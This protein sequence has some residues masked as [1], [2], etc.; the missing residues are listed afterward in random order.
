MI[1]LGTG[2]RPTSPIQLYKPDQSKTYSDFSDVAYNL[3]FFLL[4]ENKDN[5]MGWLEFISHY[6][7]DSIEI[8][9]KPAGQFET[10]TNSYT[11]FL[12]YCTKYFNKH[13]SQV[14]MCY[15]NLGWIDYFKDNYSDA[16]QNLEHGLQIQSQ[17]YG[18]E[19]LECSY[20]LSVLSNINEY[21]GKYDLAFYLGNK[22]LAIRKK[23]LPKN[24]PLIKDCLERLARLYVSVGDFDKAIVIFDKTLVINR[25]F[26]GENNP[27]TGN[28]YNLVGNL[29][30]LAE[31]F[32][33]AQENY[34]KSLQISLVFYGEFHPTVAILYN[35][36]ANIY[37]EQEKYQLSL[38]FYHK[39][40]NI[41][42]KVGGKHGKPYAKDLM[43]MGVV[44]D[45][46]GEIAKAKQHYRKSLKIRIK[47]FGEVHP[48][49]GDIYFNLGQLFDQKKHFCKS[50][51]YHQAAL[52]IRKQ[53]FG[54]K[55][56]DI[57]MSYKWISVAYLKAQET[58]KA[59]IYSE[60]KHSH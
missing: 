15:F 6:F 26:F 60:L 59:K 11:A 33:G 48:L 43:N 18:N 57:N 54:K 44:Y 23:Y 51:R 25:D 19:H 35:N 17:I 53:I 55:H 34:E 38:D 50:I 27:K 32:V 9:S 8:I 14:A 39:A 3:L 2:E 31:N 58:R 56:Q 45:E 30:S 37:S 4:Q 5:R 10:I 41:D 36:L 42:L 16:I 22:A 46:M 7:L 1:E 12:K 47:L 24:S 49:I 29:H 13:H 21:K 40:L 28:N 52:R 20:F